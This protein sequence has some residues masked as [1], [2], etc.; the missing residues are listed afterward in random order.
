M[1]YLPSVYIGTII[2][3]TINF[4]NKVFSSKNSKYDFLGLK[5]DK[6]EKNKFRG[7]KWTLKIK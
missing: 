3:N 2:R 5:F 7:L 4:I 1:K 6:L